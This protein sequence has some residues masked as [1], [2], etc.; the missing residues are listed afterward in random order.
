M[1]AAYFHRDASTISLHFGKIDVGVRSPQGGMPK[2]NQYI[3]AL[4]QAC[5]NA[6]VQTLSFA[7]I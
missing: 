6:L 7:M 5:P 2:V 3:K 1:Q 4:T